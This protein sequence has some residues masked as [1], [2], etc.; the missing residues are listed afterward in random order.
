M[1]ASIFTF[2][3]AGCVS[4][5]QNSSRI[6][7]FPM[8]DI[9]SSRSPLQ[10]SDRKQDAPVSNKFHIHTLFCKTYFVNVKYFKIN[11]FNFIS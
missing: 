3:I 8:K 9:A 11:L 5:R 10:S 2:Q 6:N 1:N 4:E 7:S